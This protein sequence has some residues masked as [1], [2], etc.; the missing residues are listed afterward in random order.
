LRFPNEEAETIDAA[1][2]AFASIYSHDLLTLFQPDFYTRVLGRQ[3]DV[4]ES[5]SILVDEG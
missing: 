2:V 4:D 3:L 5:I 1:V